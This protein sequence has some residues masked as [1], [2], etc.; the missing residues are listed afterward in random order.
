M[1]FTVRLAGAVAVVEDLEGQV[2]VVG[3]VR[4]DSGDELG[5]RVALVAV[6]NE[7]VKG[8]TD[9][10]RRD[11]VAA[12][13]V[14]RVEFGSGVGL[15]GPQ[16]VHGCLLAHADARARFILA[17]SSTNRLEMASITSDPMNALVKWV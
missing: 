1:A 8:V 14:G 2:L 16:A 3:V 10:L 12:H 6:V 13:E 17:S 9:L 7:S 4:I 15:D 5:H 11:A